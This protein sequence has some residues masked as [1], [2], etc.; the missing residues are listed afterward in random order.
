[1]TVAARDHA[2]C[3]AMLQRGSHSFAAASRL[4]P[5]RVRRPTVALYAFCRQ[6]DDAIDEAGAGAAAARARLRARLADV[7][8]GRPAGS[9]VDRA[10]HDVV[11]RYGIPLVV[12]DA[13]LEGFQWDVQR[14]QYE[15]L[16]E[17]RAYCV[18]V[19]AT[20]GAMMAVL[21]ERRGGAALARASDLGVAMQLTNIA[22]DVG[23]DARRGRI[24]LPAGWLREVGIDPQR[25]LLAPAF[26]PAL[27]QV[28]T[29]L[30]D[31]ADALY[32]RAE[33]G[34]ALL[35]ADCRTAI[36]AAALIYAEIGAVLRAHGCN[37][38]ARRVGTTRWQKL[39][40]LG[41]AAARELRARERGSQPN[42]QLHDAVLPEAR[43][44]VDALRDD[45]PRAEQQSAEAT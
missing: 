21:M 9:P 13:L 36:R 39:R 2:A 45:L 7:F 37:S 23:E 35:P 10:L 31:E 42:A 3:A 41:R 1:M 22:R 5:S 8:A 17:L 44:L 11:M 26:T 16:S 30:L 40:L 15:T 33:T 43:F 4:L 14:R 25:W 12:F 29:R 20:V 34:I 24:Y 18:R 27:G 19:G 28:V 32:A 38:V 6:A